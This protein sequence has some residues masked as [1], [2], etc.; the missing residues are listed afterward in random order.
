[1]C[2]IKR[3]TLSDCEKHKTMNGYDLQRENKNINESRNIVR[4]S[5]ARKQLKN[6]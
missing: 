5:E 3:K 1:M 2:K 6:V 4:N